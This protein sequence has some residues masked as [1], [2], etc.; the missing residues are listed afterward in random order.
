VNRFFRTLLLALLL[1]PA[2]EQVVRAV[3]VVCAEEQ[4]GC[5]EPGGPCDVD[6]MDCAC[7]AAAAITFPGGASVECLDSPPAPAVAV[8]A[9]L[10]PLAPP[11][12]ILHVPKSV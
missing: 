6:C 11:A 8:H 9:T 12:D 3:P 1:G 2:L 4:Q 7:C 10:P 5:C